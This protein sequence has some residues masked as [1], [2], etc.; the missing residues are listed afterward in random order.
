MPGSNARALDKARALPADGLIF[1]LED[2]IAA[3]AK[4]VARAQIA[5][6]LAEGGY[7]RRECVLRVNGAGTP[8]HSDDLRF[9][10]RQPVDAVLLP[11]IETGEELRAAAAALTEAGAPETLA[12]WC[13]METPL[14]FLR[15]EAIAAAS[16]R[17]SAFVVG[18]EDLAKDL[19][20]RPR[21]D[22]LPFLTALGIA[23]LAARA[24]GLAVL[25]AVYRDFRDNEGFA[26]ECRQGRDL[27]FDGKTLIHPDQIAAANAIFAPSAEEIDMAQQVIAAFDAAVATGK[28]VAT[29][30]GRMIEALHAAEAGRILALHA[31]I[32]ARG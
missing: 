18:T 30:D 26:T 32:A 8:W 23:V 12:L 19:H 2:S 21:S 24:Y 4:S 29:L 9:A 7:G 28:A 1:D 5:V 3:E 31:A 17:L 16:P 11:K 22:R 15:A 6:A 20:A 13:M 25:D 27:G 14:A 10:A